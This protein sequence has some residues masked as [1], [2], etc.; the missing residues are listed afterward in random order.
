TRDIL[1]RAAQPPPRTDA[2]NVPDIPGNFARTLPGISRPVAVS[3]PTSP[4]PAANP[5]GHSR[6]EPTSRANANRDQTAPPGVGRPSSAH[7][8]PFP[9]GVPRARKCTASAAC[10]LACA[11]CLLMTACASQPVRSENA[12]DPNAIH[13]SDRPAAD[14]SAE[15]SM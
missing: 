2:A 3:S 10:A 13:A 12:N 5:K 11:V 4:Q 6:L 7:V 8:R 15:S 14:D 1:L 9:Q